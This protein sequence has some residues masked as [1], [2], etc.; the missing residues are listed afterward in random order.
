MVLVVLMILSVT[1]SVPYRHHTIHPET[2]DC[3][4]VSV[5]EC[6]WRLIFWNTAYFQL[7][8]HVGRSIHGDRHFTVFPLCSALMLYFDTHHCVKMREAAR[9]QTEQ[10]NGIR[11][12]YAS[13]YQHILATFRVFINS[14][15]STPNI[16][17]ILLCMRTHWLSLCVS[18]SCW[19]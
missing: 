11:C 9:L 6:A 1:R 19:V 16:N 14:F 17:E 18:A 5:S 2:Q 12:S 13:L 7:W 4:S 15:Q 8:P 10:P 3:A